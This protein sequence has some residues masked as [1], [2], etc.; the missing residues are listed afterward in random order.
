MKLKHYCILALSLM[1]CTSCYFKEETEE[2]VVDIN[3]TTQSEVDSFRSGDRNIGRLVISGT[4]ITDI[5]KLFIPR[6]KELIIENTSIEE[7]ECRAL[8][9]TEDAFI[10]KNNE[11]LV[12][13]KDFGSY[14]YA[15]GVL[16]ILDNPVL[17]DISGFLSMKNIL[18]D[19]TI[20]GNPNLG[21]D[22]RGKPDSYGFNVL[23]ALANNKV[24]FGNVVLRNNH[25]DAATSISDIGLIAKQHTVG[26]R[27]TSNQECIELLS[28]GDTALFIVF[29]GEKVS[30]VGLQALK[31][32]FKVVRDSIVLRNTTVNG[33]GAMSNWTCEGAFR[34]LYNKQLDGVSMFQKYEVIGGDFILI[35]SDNA[36]TDWG[37]IKNFKEIH[38]DFI[39]DGARLWV[40][41]VPNLERVDGTF[42]VSHPSAKR[43][44]PLLNTLPTK[45]TYVGGDLRLTDMGEN[46]NTL[47]CF[48]FL[49]EI[50]GN[51]EIG[52]CGDIPLKTYD[53]I[54]WNQNKQDNDT[55]KIYG[56][57]LVR[58]WIDKGVVKPGAEIKLY[59]KSGNP[60]DVND[61]EPIENL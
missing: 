55:V 1:A 9:L 48:K 14:V 33:L 13:L 45:L 17:T 25:P 32:K 11:K 61:L 3:L 26:Y 36:K 59:D 52:R 7:L 5:S 15:G 22:R 41:S 2:D 28:E 4:D 49:E 31:D 23:K 34:M 54:T 39:L 18:A 6:V 43:V 57:D 37:Q 24:I 50:G 35:G 29:E 44:P 51:I 19:I 53:K 56:Y 20:S 42:S 40:D 27:L 60:I 21:E 10:V 8:G 12:S 30:E 47:E 58:T 38:G 16:Q 46:F